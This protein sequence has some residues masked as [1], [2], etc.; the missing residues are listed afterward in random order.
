M[1]S[2]FD[3]LYRYGFSGAVITIGLVLGFGIVAH[4]VYKPATKQIKQQGE[5]DKDAIFQKEVDKYIVLYDEDYNELVDGVALTDE[6]IT[7]LVKVYTSDITPYGE[8]SICYSKESE[9]FNYWADKQIPYKVLE[10]VAKKYVVENDCKDI[11]VDI[12]KE[13]EKKHKELN[14]TVERSEQADVSAETN[15]NTNTNTNTS[16]DTNVNEDTSSSEDSVFVKFKKYK[17]PETTVKKP[18]VNAKNKKVRGAV[19]VCDRANR[20]TYR[21]TFSEYKNMSIT[22]AVEKVK[23]IDYNSFKASFKGAKIAWGVKS[24]TGNDAN[25]CNDKAIDG[26]WRFLDVKSNE[27]LCDV[28][29]GSE[30]SNSHT[31][32]CEV[33]NACFSFNG[34]QFATANELQKYMID[35]M[36]A[37]SH[38]Y[39]TEE[40][41]SGTPTKGEYSLNGVRFATSGKLH[42]YF[43]SRLSVNNDSGSSNC[44]SDDEQFE[45]VSDMDGYLFNFDKN[46]TNGATTPDGAKVNVAGGGVLGDKK[47]TNSWLYWR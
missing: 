35:N 47:E 14:D 40:Q 21:G 30:T 3:L 43:N 26:L 41:V 1:Y 36:D 42:K 34:K 32:S 27:V 12:K 2:E 18:L 17:T 22:Q 9:S 45:N 13:L 37:S 24:A 29:C 28:E 38:I 8:I 44:C 11:Y 25:G 31:S 4:F 19:I 20:Y 5:E 7:E 15:T 16:V 10:C 23:P 46:K 33:S 39:V 6:R